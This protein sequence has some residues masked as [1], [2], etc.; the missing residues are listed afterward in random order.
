VCTDT[1]AT[2]AI[3]V[4]VP[5]AVVDEIVERVAAVVLERVQAPA[6]A[7]L[8]VDEAAELLRCKPQRVYDLLSSRRLTK[9]KDGTRVL[10]LRAELDEYL[11][12]GVAS[13][14]PPSRQ[15]GSSRAVA[16]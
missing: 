9:L 14:L 13:V 16:A 2:A 3:V 1:V 8:T 12:G 15:N 6:S 10:L 5:P 4:Q 11:A 7:Y